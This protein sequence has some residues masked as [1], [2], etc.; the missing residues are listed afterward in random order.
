MWGVRPGACQA[1]EPSKDGLA[2][3]IADPRSPTT[4]SVSV[5]ASRRGSLAAS[6][7]CSA[8]FEDLARNLT[9]AAPA[10]FR[11][12][13]RSRVHGIGLARDPSCCVRSEE[14]D[15]VGGVVRFAEPSDD[16][17]TSSFAP[18]IRRGSAPVR[19]V[20]DPRLKGQYCRPNDSMVA[21]LVSPA[22]YWQVCRRLICARRQRPQQHILKLGRESLGAHSQIGDLA[23]RESVVAPLQV[24]S[25]SASASRSTL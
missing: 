17:K 21:N 19:P 9:L 10:A 14:Q 20:G 3:E 8:T 5:A 15:H 22:L 24:A 11:M 16:V 25:R 7:R 1:K 18:R 23:I 13:T 6:D 2:S 12:R 4:S